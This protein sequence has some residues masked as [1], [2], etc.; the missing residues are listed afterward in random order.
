MKKLKLDPETL[1]VESLH[2]FPESAVT[3]TVVGNAVSN[4]RCSSEYSCM[5]YTCDYAQTCMCTNA[6]TCAGVTNCTLP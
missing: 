4:L 2:A 6:S 1:E 5:M 3:G